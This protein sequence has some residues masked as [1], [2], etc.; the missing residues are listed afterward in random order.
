MEWSLSLTGR[1]FV[2]WVSLDYN[3]ERIS[4]AVCEVL[5]KNGTRIVLAPL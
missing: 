5:E 3:A 1:N 4:Q 2:E